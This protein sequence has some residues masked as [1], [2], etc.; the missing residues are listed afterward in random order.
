MASIPSATTATSASD[1]RTKPTDRFVLKWIKIRLSARITPHLA[2]HQQLRPW[3]I[4]VT[5]AAI[6][7]LAGL[8]L[9]LGWAFT[10]GCLAALAQVLDGV[11]GQFARLTGTQT[12]AGAF[13]DS[14]LDRYA[15]GA[16][17]IGLGIYLIRLPASLPPGVLVG[18]GA[19]AL[20]GGNLISY[21]TA[22]AETLGLDLGRPTLASKG[23]RTTVVIVA[24]W[25]SLLSP[26]AP[27]AALLYLVIHPNAVVL[28]RLNRVQRAPGP[29]PGSP[30]EPKNHAFG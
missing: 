7:V 21:G 9:A 1:W 27:L 19:L 8:V 5:A 4:T 15:D 16:L 14:V 23:T 25:L 12:R 2:Q 18:L 10:A 29:T 28:M 13:W 22:R 20:I 30:P 11:D 26:L 17:V 6:G 3:M 24:A